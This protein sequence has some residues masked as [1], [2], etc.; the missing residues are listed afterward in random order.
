MV[1]FWILP[2]LSATRRV[3]TSKG[4]GAAPF[5]GFGARSGSTASRCVCCT[6]G[7][8]AAAARIQD[9]DRPSFFF[10]V[11][12]VLD[13]RRL[14]CVLDRLDVVVQGMEDAYVTRDGMRMDRRTVFLGVSFRLSLVFLVP[15]R[16]VSWFFRLFDLVDALVF[17]G[18]V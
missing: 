17:P 12:V 18:L 11:R 1:L 2:S 4:G 9:A 7:T 16:L 8:L 15:P 6:R 13:L 14:W 3:H 10:L 5:D